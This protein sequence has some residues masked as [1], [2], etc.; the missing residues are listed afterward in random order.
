MSL[1]AH[2]RVE[3]SLHRF[4]FG[5]PNSTKFKQP[6]QQLPEEV[7]SR[8]I[9]TSNG[10]LRTGTAQSSSN[11]RPCGNCREDGAQEIFREATTVSKEFF[12]RKKLLSFFKG[13]QQM[14]PFQEMLLCD[15]SKAQM[16]REHVRLPLFYHG[17]IATPLHFL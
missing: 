3:F 11:W 12:F 10:D 17:Q 9:V 8:I 6:I 7:E 5:T 16:F 2:E 15:H 1:L 4:D 14:C 13:R